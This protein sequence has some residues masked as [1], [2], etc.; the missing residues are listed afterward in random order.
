MSTLFEIDQRV[1]FAEP[2]SSEKG[3]TY[4]VSKVF[5]GPA[6]GFQ[7]VTLANYNG[8]RE[9]I[10]NNELKLGEA[11]KPAPATVVPALVAAIEAS[12]MQQEEPMQAPVQAPADDLIDGALA[13]RVADMRLEAQAYAREVIDRARA[14]EKEILAAARA[15]AKLVTGA[16][17]AEA[18][19]IRGTPIATDDRKQVYY[20]MQDIEHMRDEAEEDLARVRAEAEEDVRRMQAEAEEDLAHMRA[21]AEE[22][23]AHMRAEADES[24]QS[25]HRVQVDTLTQAQ[26]EADRL[27][28]EASRL[29]YEAQVDAEQ[30]Q[31]ETRLCDAEAREAVLSKHRQELEALSQSKEDL[32]A[33]MVHDYHVLS[34]VRANL[35]VAA[36]RLEEELMAQEDIVFK[37]F[38][39]VI[40][41]KQQSFPVAYSRSQDAFKKD[42]FSGFAHAKAAIERK[43]GQR[44]KRVELVTGL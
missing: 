7:V 14:E 3:E 11:L 42:S 28:S 40:D 30:Q 36:G 39:F 19:R 9:A 26:A 12:R 24:A 22:D 43:H 4:I 13:E 6:D 2:D 5:P 20:A 41:G 1:H 35:K 34:K 15:E 33:T 16:A 31:V 8:L 27:R 21:E 23:L 32:R 29:L 25:V 18:E 17:Y 10:W 38:T 44:V 37:H